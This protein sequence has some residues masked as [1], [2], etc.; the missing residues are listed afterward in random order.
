MTISEFLESTSGEKYIDP[1]VPNEIVSEFSYKSGGISLVG[2]LKIDFNNFREY[3]IIYRFPK[4]SSTLGLNLKN[5]GIIL[6]HVSYKD[7]VDIGIQEID[8]TQSEGYYIMIY[9]LK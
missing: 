9:M 8:P 7:E 1:G 5:L 6:N 3:S 4:D 2:L